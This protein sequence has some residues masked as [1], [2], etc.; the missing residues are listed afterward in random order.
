[1]L[2]RRQFLAGAGLAT[3]ARVAPVRAARYDLVI[4]GGLLDPSR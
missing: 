3:L 2:T 4:K 1:M